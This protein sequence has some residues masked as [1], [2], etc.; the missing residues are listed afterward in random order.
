LDDIV[1]WIQRRTVQKK[2][3][4][5]RPCEGGRGGGGGGGG[6]GGCVTWF[7]KE[8]RLLPLGTV[9]S[10]STCDQFLDRAPDLLSLGEKWEA[11]VR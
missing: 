6:D 7:D 9:W 10:T 3:E 1:S 2:V 11:K 5:A 4:V 8:G